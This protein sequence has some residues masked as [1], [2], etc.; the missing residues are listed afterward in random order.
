VQCH[1]IRPWETE[2]GR[3][4]FYWVSDGLVDLRNPCA[5]S[6]NRLLHPIVSSRNNS[7]HPLDVQRAFVHPQ[8]PSRSTS[9]PVLGVN[10][11]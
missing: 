11:M 1:F 6:R 7:V 4:A 2:P 10:L 3:T 5:E 9:L 8:M